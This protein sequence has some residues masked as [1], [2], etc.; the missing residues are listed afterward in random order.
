MTLIRQLF[1]LFDR[2]ER[3]QIFGMAALLLV[4]S[5]FDVIGI[6]LVLPFM[7]VASDPGILLQNR[8]T[9]PSLRGLGL[10]DPKSTVIAAGLVLLGLFLLKNA[11]LA[12]EWRIMYGFVYG[13]VVDLSRRL[14][15]AYLQCPYTFHLQR[16][17][18]DLISTT[19]EEANNVVSGILKRIIT[20]STE[21]ATTL[22]LLI[23]LFA[24]KPF[25]LLS[26]LAIIG[27]L[28]WAFSTVSKRKLGRLGR[29]RVEHHGRMIQWVNQS[30][31]GIKE[32]KV[33][34]REAY[35]VEAFRM[36]SLPYAEALRDSSL[37]ERYP[38]LMVETA[39]VLGLVGLVTAFLIGGA[40]LQHALPVLALFGVALV[41]LVPSVTSIVGG[42]NGIR[43]YAPSVGIVH[44]D[45]AEAGAAMAAS[46][47]AGAS[48]A[49]AFHDRIEINELTYSY[50]DGADPA[51][52]RVT[53]MIPRG[54]T[55]AFVGTSG[56]GKTTLVNLLLGLLEPTHGQILVD[57]IS[58]KG[59]LAGW[60][61]QLGY[62]PQDI[63][64]S[65]ETLRMN[66]AFGVPDA[67]IDDAAIWQALESAQLASFVRALPEQLQTMVGERGI[68]ISAGQRQRIGIARALYHSPE[69]LVLD[70]ATSALD[71]ETE[72]QFVSA[73]TS[74]SKTKTI[75]MVAH[76]LS[77]VRGASV[78]YVLS[79]GRIAGSGTYEE[80]LESNP[81]FQQLVYAA[82]PRPEESIPA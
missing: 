43:F 69:L 30:L 77:T 56:A 35:F 71:T 29:T 27:C 74:L 80:L 81:T 67:E 14:L 12:Y 13:K 52:D 51:L 28:G 79:G 72:R 15:A 37:T 20:I 55:V 76:R 58:I 32:V 44:R 25:V 65:D 63:Y 61:R 11:F 73:V 49:V 57:G 1:S 3:L 39:A 40:D 78:I 53:L 45:L 8:F 50:Q 22:G 7:K 60:Q 70:E 9:G 23:L 31:G 59:N 6:G 66:V 16:N 34:G 18:A 82:E 36:S 5:F 41:R 47:Q 21:A 46:T 38:R 17:T 68:R 48:G 33:L 75:I 2:R 54:R 10:T 24:A 26:G 64:L 19:T 62:I 42:I 4:G